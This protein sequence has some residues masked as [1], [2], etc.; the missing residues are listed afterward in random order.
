MSFSPARAGLR[1]SL[2]GITE[3]WFRSGLDPEKSSPEI[4][5]RVETRQ[6]HPE[7]QGG[8]DRN[9]YDRPKAS[10]RA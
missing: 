5:E 7:G 2:Q 9:P 10:K 3:L 4:L 8:E 6:H 1:R